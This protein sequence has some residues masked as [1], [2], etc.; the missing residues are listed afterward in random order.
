MYEEIV[1][2]LKDRLEIQVILD[3]REPT[4]GGEAETD[5]RGPDRRRSQPP[6]AVE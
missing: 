6:F 1:E 2:L 4:G 5:W 3:R